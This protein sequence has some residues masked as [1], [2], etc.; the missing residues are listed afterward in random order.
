[1]TVDPA[2]SASAALNTQ[3]KAVQRPPAPPV[4]LPAENP[5]ENPTITRP[6][7]PA[8]Q[9]QNLSPDSRLGNFIDTTA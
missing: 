9:P 5:V 3:S 2:G 4:Q 7:N 8:T 1:M 6:V